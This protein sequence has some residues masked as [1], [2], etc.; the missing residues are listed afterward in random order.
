M[1][2]QY[3]SDRRGAGMGNIRAQGEL[4]CRQ[5]VSSME[6]RGLKNKKDLVTTQLSA[7]IGIEQS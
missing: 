4:I 7:I 6:A 3:L 5:A 1:R 2:M